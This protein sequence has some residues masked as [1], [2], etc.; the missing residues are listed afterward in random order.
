MFDKF[1]DRLFNGSN[2]KEIKKFRKIVEQRIN[3]LEDEMRNLSILLWLTRRTNL[4]PVWRR[5]KLWM[6]FYQKHLL[7]SVK[8][9]AVF[10]VCAT[11]M[12]S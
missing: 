10:L 5:E 3:P 4:R 11:L 1:F 2:E 12:F 7:L 8:R 6:T 9:P